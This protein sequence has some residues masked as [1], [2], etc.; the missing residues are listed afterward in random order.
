LL[1]TEPSMD[2]ERDE[3]HAMDDRV[4]GFY[5]NAMEEQSAGFNL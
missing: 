4:V 3:Q 1:S 5:L 2:R